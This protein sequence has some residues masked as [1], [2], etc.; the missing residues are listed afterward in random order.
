MIVFDASGSMAGNVNQGI[1]TTIPRIDEVRGAL[2]TVLP[3]VTR[4]RRVGLRHDDRELLAAVAGDH[5]DLAHA[6]LDAL[7]DAA[8][9]GVARGAAAEIVD[10]A[11]LV[12]SVGPVSASVRLRQSFWIV[13]GMPR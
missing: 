13:R 10:G 4:A 9:H 2:A 7:G 8:D 3:T 12:D 6:L 5:V 11:E 1:A